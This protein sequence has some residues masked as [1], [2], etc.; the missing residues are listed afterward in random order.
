[1]VIGLLLIGRL[2]IRFVSMSRCFGIMMVMGVGMGMGM[3]E[4]DLLEK[5]MRGERRPESQEQE[6]ND[7]PAIEHLKQLPL[8]GRK[9]QGNSGTVGWQ[10]WQ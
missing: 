4:A 3:N 1:M 8:C 10:A 9:W 2:V 6:S 5:G 7:P